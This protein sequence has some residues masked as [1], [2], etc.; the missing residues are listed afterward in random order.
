[1]KGLRVGE[2]H[3]VNWRQVGG[4]GGPVLD[5]RWVGH[6]LDQLLGALD[7]REVRQLLDRWQLEALGLIGVEHRVGAK[8]GEPPRR[9]L[10]ALL[11]AR[12]DELPEGDQGALLAPTNVAAGL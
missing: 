2:D 6:L 1:M 11:L 7:R 9:L 8:E 3:P 5:R 10:G 4:V 12:L